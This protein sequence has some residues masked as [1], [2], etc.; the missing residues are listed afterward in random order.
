MSN[1]TREGLFP[2]W[3]LWV[4]GPVTVLA[5]ALIIV[6][7]V[8]GIQAGQRQVEIQRRQQ[9]GIAL[10]RAIDYRA[11][12]RLQE[13]L[14]E[15]Q[16][17]LVLDP[18][19][20]TAQEGINN[21]VNQAA[22]GPPAVVD[23][24]PAPAEPPDQAP[25]PPA[26]AAGP[27]ATGSPQQEQLFADALAA[28]Q[29]GD[30]QTAAD[31]LVRLQQSAPTFQASQVG[32]MLY[33]CY[34]N[35]AATMDKA[36]NVE[37]ALAY[38]DKALALEPNSS[39]L[40][41]ARTVIAKYVDALALEGKD[42][43]KMIALL[44]EIYVQDPSYRDVETRLQQALLAYGDQLALGKEW[45][46]AEAQYTAAIAISVTPGSIARRDE[47]QA[48]CQ[49]IAQLTGVG[50]PT[51]RAFELTPVPDRAGAPGSDL[52]A[53]GTAGTPAAD[54]TPEAAAGSPAE[55]TAE[56][57][58]E[59]TVEA[60]DAA[61]AAPVAVGAPAGRILL[62]ALDPVN[63]RN[64]VLLQTIGQQGFPAIL[65]EE[66]LQPAFRPDGQRLVYRN[67]R[68]DSR[69]LTAL[70]PATGLTLR[71]TTFSEDSYP[72]WNAEG[73]LVA[74]ASN[75]EGDRRWRIYVVWADVN[76]EA[77]AMTFG[78][79]P[80]GNPAADQLAYRGCDDS[81]NN[82]GIWSM[83]WSGGNRRALTTVPADSQ[84][85]W[86]P[87]G[88]FLAFMSDGRDGNPEVYKVDLTT[89]QTTRLTDNPAIDGQPAVS[90]DGSWVAFLSN[91]SGGWAV[92]AVPS[93][94]GEAQMLFVLEGGVGNWQEQEIQWLN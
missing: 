18:G 42:W 21:L 40:R 56:A 52:A 93:S 13:A 92:W 79:A 25:T 80:A 68:G 10:Q 9:V 3:V 6:A 87:T 60:T 46:D 12:G 71:F 44:E 39:A 15:Y 47:F 78:E 85:N 28:Y 58:V 69:G 16:R 67:L 37:E 74:F 75:R 43:A 90:P 63:G 81:G 89:G 8:L 86:S 27:T 31:T 19:N 33:N 62:S 41:A 49:A 11:E 22:S 26:A 65:A 36:G 1:E 34:V 29:T 14:A 32:E 51:P 83:S 57:S 94:G 5:A 20:T 45:C 54:A 38:V 88:R 59:V 50:T 55:S 66:G 76:N 4:I 24:T 7:V 91:R 30:W 17:V 64:L 35:L 82:C 72:T 73:N 23:G 77:T 2:T 61:T 53:L 48:K 70:D 84:P